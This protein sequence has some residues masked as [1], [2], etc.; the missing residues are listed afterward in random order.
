VAFQIHAGLLNDCY[1]SGRG[2]RG[3]IFKEDIF[4]SEV[5]KLTK[6]ITKMKKGIIKMAENSQLS[7]TR[8]VQDRTLLI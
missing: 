7:A 8:K 3:I 4:F 2:G 5:F 1:P 6:I